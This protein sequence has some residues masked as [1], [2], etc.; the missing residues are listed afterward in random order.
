MITEPER[1]GETISDVCIAFGVSE[2]HGT[3]GID[4]MMHMA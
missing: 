3:N 2:K 1:S 4:D